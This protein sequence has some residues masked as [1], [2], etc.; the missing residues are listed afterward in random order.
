MPSFEA[1]WSLE[2]SLTAALDSKKGI[3]VYKCPYR[4]WE[5]STRS[6]HC[7][8]CFVHI[9]LCAHRLLASYVSWASVDRLVRLSLRRCV[10]SSASML[11]VHQNYASG[12][13]VSEDAAKEFQDCIWRHLEA[14]TQETH[15][16]LPW[17]V[18]GA[19][20]DYGASETQISNRVKETFIKTISETACRLPARLLPHV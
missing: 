17:G 9:S 20:L 18:P 7:P 1:K 15:H 3:V 13:V 4:A 19:L 6:G 5:Y 11:S 16:G 2:L 12:E 8:Y 14:S 10:S